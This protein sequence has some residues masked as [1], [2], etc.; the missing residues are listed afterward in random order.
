MC[1]REVYLNWMLS[2]FRVVVGIMAAIVW[3]GYASQVCL[4]A[5]AKI[6]AKGGESPGRELQGAYGRMG[7]PIVP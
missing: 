1:T 7:G 3:L 5:T 4:A 6:I 2:S